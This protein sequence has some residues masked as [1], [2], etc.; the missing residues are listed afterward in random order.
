MKRFLLMFVALFTF[1]IIHVFAEPAEPK[2]LHFDGPLGTD[3]DAMF[4]DTDGDGCY[5]YLIIWVNGEMRHR[6]R[7]LITTGGHNGQPGPSDWTEYTGIIDARWSVP[8]DT[9][10]MVLADTV[11]DDSVAIIENTTAD[12]ENYYWT[13]L[14]PSQL[15]TSVSDGT[16]SVDH[17]R[18]VPN[19]IGDHVKVVLGNRYEVDAISITSLSGQVYMIKTWIV[20]ADGFQF[21]LPADLPSGRYQLQYYFKSQRF[22]VPFITQK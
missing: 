10:M 6:G 11:T 9:I 7:L 1:T 20:T 21:E 2:Y 19:P 4:V 3:I 15:L 22:S 17:A 5:D 16:P 12:P 14:L 18:I 8:D 13:R